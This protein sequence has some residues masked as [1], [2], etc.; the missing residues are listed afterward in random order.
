[1]GESISRDLFDKR[2]NDIINEFILHLGAGQDLE[3]FAR[4]LR[5][6]HY[7]YEI[8]MNPGRAKELNGFQ[9]AQAKRE[10]MHILINLPKHI[11]QSI[12]RDIDKFLKPRRH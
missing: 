1:M 4:N 10:A 7:L 3:K 2:I 6:S 8:F 9:Q 11:S 5:S 12:N